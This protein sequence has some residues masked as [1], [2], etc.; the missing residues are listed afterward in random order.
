MSPDE[1]V[2]A[3]PPRIPLPVD[4]VL[5]LR[6]INPDDR[7][8][9]RVRRASPSLHSRTA[10][11]ACVTDHQSAPTAVSVKLRTIIDRAIVPALLDRL[12]A[13]R[14]QVSSPEAG[15]LPKRVES[16]ASV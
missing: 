12:L 5:M 10:H 4:P 9:Q 15:Q 16:T 7:A 6:P 11:Y 1:S 8:D 2:S 13:K 14:Y 3:S